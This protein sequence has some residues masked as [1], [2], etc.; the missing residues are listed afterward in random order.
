MILA[1]LHL[2]VTAICIRAEQPLLGLFQLIDWAD[3]PIGEAVSQ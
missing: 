3:S 1:S 2:T